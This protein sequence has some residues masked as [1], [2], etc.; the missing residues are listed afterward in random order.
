MKSLDTGNLGMIE[1]EDGTWGIKLEIT[2]SRK[3][4]ILHQKWDMSDDEITPYHSVINLLRSKIVAG[5]IQPEPKR[6]KK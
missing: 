3:V 4:V 5:E 1:A 6:R 2:R